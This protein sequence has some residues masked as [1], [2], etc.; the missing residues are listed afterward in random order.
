MNLLNF[1]A[2]MAFL[3]VFVVLACVPELS[4]TD[5]ILQDA[6]DNKTSN[7]Q[8]RGEGE[9]TK[10]LSDDTVGDR[11]QRF[12]VTLESGQSLLFA[13][14]IDIAGRID[15]IATGK[16]IEFYGVYEWNDEGGVIH[17]THHDLSGDHIDGWL[18]Y[19]GVTYQ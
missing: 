1:K 10:L 5:Q 3:F 19:N 18:K 13:H 2:A 12:I 4:K 6:F 16:N 8:V 7:L 14:N 9:V 17:W 11:H 15:V